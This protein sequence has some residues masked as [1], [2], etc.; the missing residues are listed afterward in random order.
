[1]LCIW[2]THAPG[3]KLSSRYRQTGSRLQLL[4]LGLCSKGKRQAS[5]WDGAHLQRMKSL[6]FWKT[7]MWHCP[8]VF[9]NCH[10]PAATSAIF[11]SRAFLFS[12]ITP[13]L[14]PWSSLLSLGAASS[15]VAFLLKARN[16]QLIHLYVSPTNVCVCLS[17]YF[18]PVATAFLLV[19]SRDQLCCFFSQDLVP[20]ALFPHPKINS[21]LSLP[22]LFIIFQ[23]SSSCWGRAKVKETFKMQQ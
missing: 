8:R 11:H 12:L 15:A 9:G 6:P 18:N 13:K 17:P 3:A 10:K 23:A 20:F 19:L 21:N 2:N 4:D 1:M 22:P 7:T 14:H 16:P 5:V